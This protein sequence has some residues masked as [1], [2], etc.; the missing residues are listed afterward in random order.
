MPS[1]GYRIE[2]PVGPSGKDGLPLGPCEYLLRGDGR[3]AGLGQVRGGGRVRP[4]VRLAAAKDDGGGVGRPVP[5]DLPDPL[6]LGRGAFTYDVQRGVSQTV[7]GLHSKKGLS[8]VN[9]ALG[10]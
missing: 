4:E 8:F 7:W 1:P 2:Q 5:P 9:G 3:A 10:P 6:V